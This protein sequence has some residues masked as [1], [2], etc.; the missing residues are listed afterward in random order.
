[1][2]DGKMEGIYEVRM[3]VK[4]EKDSKNIR[5]IREFTDYTTGLKSYVGFGVIGLKS[6]GR[7]VPQEIE[8]EFKDVYSVEKAFELYDDAKQAECDR[9]IQMLEQ[10][11]LDKS[12]QIILPGQ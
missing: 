8:F 7:T 3:F 6:Q 9:F 4:L 1:M 12:K 10:A 11:R 2:G 5:T